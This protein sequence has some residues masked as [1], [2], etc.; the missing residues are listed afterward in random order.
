[1]TLNVKEH[2]INFSVTSGPNSGTIEDCTFARTEIP[3]GRW[4]FLAFAFT[5]ARLLTSGEGRLYINGILT[6]RRPVR[7]TLRGT[8]AFQR[9]TVGCMWNEDSNRDPQVFFGQFGSVSFFDEALTNTQVQEICAL[10]PNYLGS[11][12]GTEWERCTLMNYSCE[13]MSGDYSLNNIPTSDDKGTRRAQLC[14]VGAC[15][16]NSFR[17]IV[18]CTEGIKVLFPLIL[19]LNQPPAA[20]TTERCKDDAKVLGSMMDLIHSI[21]CGSR[22]MEDEMLKEHGYAALARVLKSIPAR[23]ISPTLVL[24]FKSAYNALGHN[25]AMQNSLYSELLTDFFL[26]VFTP[27]SVQAELAD[28]LKYIDTINDKKTAVHNEK[29]IGM[30]VINGNEALLN[31]NS[32]NSGTG[33]CDIDNIY[34]KKKSK[35]EKGD[36][37]ISDGSSSSAGGSGDS[38]NSDTNSGGTS[39]DDDDSGIIH[40]KDKHTSISILQIMCIVRSFYWDSP[41]NPWYLCKDVPV[42]PHTGEALGARLSGSEAVKICEK[43]FAIITQRIEAGKLTRKDIDAVLGFI[44]AAAATTT[45]GA[46][47]AQ[48]AEIV[49]ALL[50]ALIRTTRSSVT[51]FAE[52]F[53]ERGGM[54]VLHGLVGAQNEDLQVHAIDA[55]AYLSRALVGC[56]GRTVKVNVTAES[57]HQ[58]IMKRQRMT[59]KTYNSLIRMAVAIPPSGSEGIMH[60]EYPEVLCFCILQLAL[61]AEFDVRRQVLRDLSTLF[62]QGVTNVLR[63]FECK[64]WQPP[65]C[66]FIASFSKDADD[67]IT[68]LSSTVVANILIASVVAAPTAGG[69]WN[70]GYFIR[71]LSDF[72]RPNVTDFYRTIRLN[73]AVRFVQTAQKLIA[74]K[75]SIMFASVATTGSGGDVS[76]SDADPSFDLRSKALAAVQDEGNPL[77]KKTSMEAQVLVGIILAEYEFLVRTLPETTGIPTLLSQS[78]ETLPVTATPPLEREQSQWA[79]KE[80]ALLTEII[81]CFAN[82]NMLTLSGWGNTY[83]DESTI[84]ISSPTVTPIVATTEEATVPLSGEA[85][86]TTTTNV[87]VGSG[88]AGTNLRVSGAVGVSVLAAERILQIAGRIGTDCTGEVYSALDAMTTIVDSQLNNNKGS[89]TP[90][91]CFILLS[92]VRSALETYKN[93]NVA[94]AK[95]EL[96]FV[97]KMLT[98]AHW[99]R[100]GFVIKRKSVLSKDNI[101]L[102]TEMSKT[103]LASPSADLE[104]AVAALE[105][106]EWSLIAEELRPL[107]EEFIRSARE[108]ENAVVAHNER[109]KNV[110][111]SYW[112]DSISENQNYISSGQD[113]IKTDLSRIIEDEKKRL[114]KAYHKFLENN[115]DSAVNTHIHIH[116]HT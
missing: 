75:S 19:S 29:L 20:T 31:S 72:G 67:E 48:S 80:A 94:I 102:V 52:M 7:L 25:I 89:P 60:L 66:Q 55:I 39:D 93:N 58:S 23:F 103:S 57:L 9:N 46:D 14:G 56:P 21:I 51:R 18:V 110:A 11:F 84:S 1:M 92:T 71:L 37:G 101:T 63:V 69:W 100:T 79:H 104:A 99:R 42:S 112:K 64:G 88:N 70:I 43:L 81:S 3:K 53:I 106:K 74:S 16:V 6:E 85:N 50:V 107:A 36:A 26:W 86:V 13:A 12:Q 77:F 115:A 113:C 27:F 2:H 28:L 109:V 45:G 34:D 24:G 61:T 95:E 65:F 41:N 83:E 44:S 78:V 108:E 97:H 114:T 91:F 59:S 8:S 47:E 40:V 87:N 62:E 30:K 96:E 38:S 90:I 76:S 32:A 33:S 105:S 4:F 17:E 22:V 10:G 54:S 82:L 98:K 49:G 35:D 15:R 111:L 73:S 5:P 116:I 68:S